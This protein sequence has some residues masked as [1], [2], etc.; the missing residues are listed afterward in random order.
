M[1]GESAQLAV[2]GGFS[3]EVMIADCTLSGGCR[4]SLNGQ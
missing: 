4:E 2:R 3:E 1:I